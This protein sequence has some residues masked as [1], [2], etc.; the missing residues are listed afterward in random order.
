MNRLCI[1][2]GGDVLHTGDCPCLPLPLSYTLGTV[3]QTGDLT[4]Q[5]K[6]YLAGLAGLSALAMCWF[7]GVRGGDKPSRT[8]VEFNRDIRPIL[9][10]TCFVCHGPDNNLRKA[11][12]RLDQEKD[13]LK[14]RGNYSIIVPGNP[15]KSELYLRISDPD[16]KKR[17]PP[18]KHHTQLSKEQ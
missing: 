8:P 12:L 9:S 4:M 15:D 10:N 18:A 6:M 3:T 14:K 17:M 11:K 1:R 16:V 7:P 2:S 13:V 5:L